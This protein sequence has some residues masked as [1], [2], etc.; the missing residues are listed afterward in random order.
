M[1]LVGLI[2]W[3]AKSRRWSLYSDH[4]NWIG[5]WS[6]LITKLPF[7]QNQVGVNRYSF[8]V[9]RIELVEFVG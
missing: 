8:H 1:I 9:G 4:A 5:S 7:K 3:S 6:K 2:G